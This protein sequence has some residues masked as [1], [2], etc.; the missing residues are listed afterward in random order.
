MPP[1]KFI[2]GLILARGRTRIDQVLNMVPADI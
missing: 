2:E 1:D